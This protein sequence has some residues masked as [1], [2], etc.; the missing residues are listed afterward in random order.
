[1]E[2]FSTDIKPFENIDLIKDILDLKPDDI[3]FI[4]DI[5]WASP[6]CTGFSVASC[7]K[8]WKG[9]GKDSV[10]VTETA[11]L[12]IKLV[13]KTLKI[14]RHFQKLNPNLVWYIENPRGKLRFQSFMEKL[15]IRHTVTYC[16]YG[17]FRMKPT[18]IWTN[19]RNWKP[20]PM[21]K[22]RAKCHE[23]ATRGSRG[24]MER[25]KNNYERSKV[26]PDLCFK[27]IAAAREYAAL[28]NDGLI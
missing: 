5:I 13:K 26:P 15:P 28:C 23:S 25:L 18:D 6:P 27:V 12:G 17:D 4:P 7:W 19:N 24:G 1:M 2:V 10:P 22:P 11:L 21:C 9:S 20:K 3:P 14:I 16:Q 8:H